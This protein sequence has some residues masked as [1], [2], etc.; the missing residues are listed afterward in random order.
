MSEHCRRKDNPKLCKADF[1]RT[2]WL[3]DRAVVLCHGLGSLHGPMN[4]ESLNGTHPAMLA[5]QGCNSDVQLPY[6]FPVCPATHDCDEDCVND[7]DET[8][9]V[10]AAQL[11]N[12]YMY[13][14]H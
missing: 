13:A 10:D 9:I 4:H 12:T 7:L 8:V 3:I 14:N 11:A 2:K 6:R 1:P 5:A